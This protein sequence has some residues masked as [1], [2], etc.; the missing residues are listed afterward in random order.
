MKSNSK[1]ICNYKIKRFRDN[2]LSKW[3]S[4]TSILSVCKEIVSK[5]WPHTTIPLA[6]NS[7][8]IIKMWK[9]PGNPSRSVELTW[10]GNGV[11]YHIGTIKISHH[12]IG[13]GS[14]K[15][16]GL[17]Q[18][19]R[20][21]IAHPSAKFRLMIFTPLIPRDPIWSQGP[22]S[23]KRRIPTVQDKAPHHRLTEYADER[24][25]SEV[26]WKQAGLRCAQAFDRRYLHRSQAG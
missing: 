17:H 19:S 5:V 6:F 9:A 15:E 26:V 4:S 16:E 7:D 24:V 8:I 11:R 20:Y 1:R 23:K 14:V 10:S 18:P 12:A 21:L 13:A 2:Q 3:L 22:K 25:P